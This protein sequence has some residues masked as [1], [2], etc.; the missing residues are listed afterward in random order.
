MLKRII[1]LVSMALLN[2]LPALTTHAALQY[3]PR[4]QWK[5]TETEHFLIHYH[6]ELASLIPQLAQQAEAIHHQESAFFGWRP[7]SK[8]H[9]VLSDRI[10]I[11]NGM[12]T[13]LPYNTI[14]LFATPPVDIAGLEDYDDWLRI[15]LQ[16]EYAHILHTDKAK[17][18]PL[19]LRSAFGRAPFFLLF[20]LFPNILQPDWAIEG[21]ATYRETDF[22]RGLGRGQSSYFRALMR[23]EW[24][25]GLKSLRTVNQPVISW[26][27]GITRY[28]YGVYFYRFLAQQY[29]EQAIRALIDDYSTFP[30]PFLL[31]YSSRKVLGKNYYQLWQEFEA[32]IGAEM[33]AEIIRIKAQG[34]RTGQAL[35]NSGYRSGYSRAAE[36]GSIFYLH[37]DS[38]SRQQLM[39]LN[40]ATGQRTALADVYGSGHF[41]Y[42][43]R[44]GIVLP[45]LDI[46]ISVNRLYD[47]YRLD[48]ASGRQQR[49]T[50]S[51][52]YHTATW[53]PDGQRLI[54]VHHE[55]GSYALHLLDANGQH[56]ETLWQGQAMEIF[57]GDID[58]SPL[59]DGLAA[60]V[61]RKN[62][63]WNIE[64]FD[65]QLRQWHPLAA[66][67]AQEGQPQF[68]N[69]GR[70][71]VYSADHQGIYNI[72]Q[73]ELSNKRI[74]RLT[75]VLGAALH[76]SLSADGAWLYY[77]GL[78]KNGFNLHR[79]PVQPA[80][81]EMPT[82]TPT[83]N[84]SAALPST[85]SQNVLRQS[86]Y[87]ALHHIT[88][89]WW[90]PSYFN[91]GTQS[92]VSLITSGNDPLLWHDYQLELGYDL[93]NRLPNFFLQ[94]TYDRLRP[95]IRISISRGYRYLQFNSGETAYI[96]Q[97]D[98]LQAIALLP[99]YQ[100]DKQ[101]SISA[102]LAYQ[103][104]SAQFR[105]PGL[106]PLSTRQDLFA[107]IAFDHDSSQQ[108]SRAVNRND[109]TKLHIRLETSDNRQGDYSGQTAVTDIHHYSPV[110]Q[111]SIISARLLLGLESATMRPFEFGSLSSLEAANLSFG[112]RRYILRGYPSGLTQLSGNAINLMTLDWSFPIWL[113]ES[114]IML[115]P[116]GLNRIHGKLFAEAGRAWNWNTRPRPFS[117]SIGAELTA[118]TT[119]AFRGQINLIFGYAKGLDQYGENQIYITFRLPLP[120]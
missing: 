117:R 21:V 119:L 71:L 24:Q 114:G 15:V 68:S 72:Y 104:E 3:D 76:P 27:G 109:G 23:N 7:A 105:Y 30:V 74:S 37:D 86:D 111:R 40:P 58:W 107:G 113:L 42:H 95:N 90:L 25:H 118:E 99:F 45:Q 106:S 84:T 10:D 62:N 6:S 28:L 12:A 69:D 33:E 53:S 85:E 80:P 59:G 41:D 56:L 16:H 55:A 43:P 108:R 77:S 13:P 112:K 48:P 26:P 18:F 79:I 17:G 20:P 47:L 14:Y 65:L 8:T 50:H 32:A 120:G 115:P 110:I 63:G 91:D 102:G 1:W 96:N 103:S 49:L 38:E 34:L 52:R 64:W 82:A 89:R 75:Q 61:W 97:N 11:A 116:I 101:Q 2:V 67:S 60:A 100:K 35:S 29:G 44:A 94:Y 87:Q 57:I 66:T 70:Y 83:N 78:G 92:L 98:R 81:A 73:L 31:N 36:D 93:R 22:E 51:G 4:L 88:P 19:H 39:R 54:A 5:T 9:I 46:S